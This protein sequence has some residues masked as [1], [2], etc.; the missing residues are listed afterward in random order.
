MYD[1]AII[2]AGVVGAFVARELARYKL[3]I[4]VLEK[5]SD[6]ACGVTKAN[7]A[8]V[9]SGYSPEPGTLKAE[10]N[11]KASKN[12]EKYCE[13][14]DVKFE[15]IGS[16]VLTFDET[17]LDEL[18]EKYERGQE[19]GVEGLE[20]IDK[21]R[22]LELEPG[23][24]QDMIKALYAPST[25]IVDPW[26]FC[27]A[28]AENAVENGV[29]LKLEYEVEDIKKQQDKF[30]IS[31][32]KEQ[33]HSKI[34]INCAG[35]YSD[36]INNM[37]TEPSFK[38]IPGRGQY[39]V[40]DREIRDSIKHVLFQKTEVRGIIIA[41][42]VHGNVL[43]G[44]N[45]N[46][47]EDKT[48][49]RTTREGLEFVKEASE[50][51]KEDIPFDKTIK[52]FAGMRPRP[53]LIVKDESTGEAIL[54][55][56]GI[57]DF[58]IE[59]LDEVRGFINVAGI[60]SPGL[61]CAPAIGEYVA[62]IIKNNFGDLESNNNFNPIRRKRIRFME[63]SEEEKNDLINKDSRYG[64]VVCR[65]E[66]ITE[67]E[68]VDAIHRKVGATTVDGIKRRLRPGMGKCQ[69]SY[70]T[71]KVMDILVREWEMKPTLIKKESGNSYM[72]VGG[73]K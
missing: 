33:I 43:V 40:L 46:D 5:E 58:I 4:V 69:G 54:V 38:I 70:C 14:L 55:D 45:R 9:H 25:G 10:L 23:I 71:P 65:C 56:D 60:K 39:Y 19:N 12:F 42:T 30:E 52:T 66:N 53:E 59:E 22:A 13:Q 31:T 6:V 17:G 11:I 15:R 50:I 51:I 2:G 68:I 47:L 35:L 44:P 24:N 3:D 32:N 16:L 72:L 29:E 8:I 57:Q 1:V 37:V 26:E 41:P 63:L 48:D 21:D 27:I 64:N 18:L 73:I 49:L 7:T 36:E 34:I 62:E 61:T 67:G 20:I 28:A